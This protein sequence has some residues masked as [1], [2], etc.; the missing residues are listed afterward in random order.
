MQ[1]LSRIEVKPLDNYLHCKEWKVVK[2]YKKCETS[3]IRWKCWITTAMW[4][5]NLWYSKKSCHQ[6]WSTCD[7]EV[8]ARTKFSVFLAQLPSVIRTHLWILDAFICTTVT[9]IICPIFVFSFLPL[10]VQLNIIKS[11]SSQRWKWQKEWQPYL[12]MNIV[13]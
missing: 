6:E 9:P 8:E 7:S 10:V 11:L 13:L 1:H 12:N 2:L 3:N 4:G 5:S